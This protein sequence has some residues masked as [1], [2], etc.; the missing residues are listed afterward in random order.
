VFRAARE[1]GGKTVL[2]VVTPGPARYLERLEKL[3]PHV[4]VFLPNNN[5][6]E[7]ITGETDPLRQAMQFHKLGAGTSIITMGGEG[8]VLV[9]DRLRVKAG[10]HSVPFVDGSG[11]GDAFD[12]G[13]VYGLLH[14]LDAL[15]CLRIASALGASCVQAV[16]TT[17]GVFTRTQCEEFLRKNR[18]PIEPI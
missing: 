7:L 1:A 2:D 13:Y 9:S 17:T 11:G 8:A 4:D 5:E 6:A 3:L 18:L 12:A 10:V 14:G 15:E 16:S